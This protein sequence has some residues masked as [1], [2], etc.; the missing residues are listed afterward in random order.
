MPSALIQHLH[1]LVS[2]CP[3]RLPLAFASDDVV[4]LVNR[5]IAAGA[6]RDLSGRR[7]VEPVDAL[8]VAADGRA[9]PVRH[10]IAALFEGSGIF[11]TQ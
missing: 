4:G 9:W 11:I 10:G 1:L 2:P 8:L 5:D 3:Q 6:V 7:V